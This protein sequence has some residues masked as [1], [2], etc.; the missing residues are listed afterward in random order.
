MG[1]KPHY[2]FNVFGKR[3]T[4]GP[5]MREMKKCYLES[6]SRGISYMK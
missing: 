2:P 6:V 4:V 5:I 1:K 3:I